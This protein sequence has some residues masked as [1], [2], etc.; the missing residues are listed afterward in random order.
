MSD[1]QD[2]KKVGRK[3]TI[4]AR[5]VRL[6]TTIGIVMIILMTACYQIFFYRRMMSSARTEV[7]TLAYAFSSAVS[8]ADIYS[9]RIL[10][11]IFVDFSTGSL[12]DAKGYIITHQGSVV[13]ATP[14]GD[15]IHQGD[16]IVD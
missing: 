6:C 8:N 16:N 1:T 13:S 3:T 5:I 14:E 15:L 11:N 7:N 2:K 4:K 10:D 12:N 9:N